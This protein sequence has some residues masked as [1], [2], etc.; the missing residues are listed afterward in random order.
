MKKIFLALAAVASC[1]SINAQQLKVMK[2][3]NVVATYKATQADKVVFAEEEPSDFVSIGIGRYTDD[4]LAP[5]FGGD[6]VG[7]DVEIME[8]SKKPGLYRIMNAYSNSVYPF[9]DDDCAAEGSYLEVDAQDPDGVFIT[10]QSLGFDWGYGEFYLASWGGYMIEAGN[11]FDAVKEAG[12]LGKLKD[13]VITFPVLRSPSEIDYQGLVFM[14]TKGYYT[15]SGN[16][17]IVLPSAAAK[18]P[19]KAK[20][21]AADLESRAFEK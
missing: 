11:S 6:A 19:K 18:S 9:A 10:T 16:W 14:G 15:G 13:G 21:V 20:R 5:M 8:H 1:M 3:D 2:G 12:L 7:Y 4:C 17:Q